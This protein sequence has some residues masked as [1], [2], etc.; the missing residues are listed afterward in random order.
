M[1]HNPFQTSAPNRIA[2]IDPMEELTFLFGKFGW[3][4]RLCDL[5]ENQVISLLYGIQEAKKIEASH[6]IANIERAYF[7]STGA[8]PATTVPF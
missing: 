4:T 1:T 6:G 3:E 5:T 2:P 8:W 7:E